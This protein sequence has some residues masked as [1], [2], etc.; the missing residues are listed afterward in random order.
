[1]RKWL[2]PLW[3]QPINFGT[4][5]AGLFGGLIVPIS[6]IA[7]TEYLETVILT[8]ANGVYSRKWFPYKQ[9]AEQ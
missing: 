3:L 1:M 6:D 4:F 9:E 5:I 7:N 8:I 2:T